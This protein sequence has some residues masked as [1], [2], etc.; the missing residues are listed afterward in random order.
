[1]IDKVCF[2]IGGGR[3]AQRKVK[4]LLK[5]KAKVKLI[6]PTLNKALNNLMQTGEIEWIQDTYKKKYIKNCRIIFGATNDTD[7]NEKIY[8]D[9]EKFGLLCNV[10]DKIK[11]CNFISPAVFTKDE[12]KVAVSTAGA[13]PTIAG[14]IKEEIGEKIIDKYS[15]LV[16]LLGRYRSEILNLTPGKRIVFWEKISKRNRIMSNKL[17]K[18]KL[19]KIIKLLLNNK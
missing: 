7:I 2:V 18:D 1:M 16:N 19:E 13:A 12:I 3:V 9:A 8:N 17:N 15:N 4:D 10:V 5:C 6:S 11:F 14:K